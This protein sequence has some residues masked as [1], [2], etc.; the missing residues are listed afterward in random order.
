MA[1]SISLKT[2]SLSF[3]YCLTYHSRKTDLFFVPLLQPHYK[4]GYLFGVPVDLNLHLPTPS[5]TPAR[6]PGVVFKIAL[7][8]LLAKKICPKV[9]IFNSKG[10]GNFFCFI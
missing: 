8:N 4:G 9:F 6:R 1:Y 10:L 5:H 2:D 3:S 7:R